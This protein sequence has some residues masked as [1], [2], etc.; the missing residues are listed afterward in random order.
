MVSYFS[1]VATIILTAHFDP[2]IL[3]LTFM[4]TW[5]NNATAPHT[6]LFSF[7]LLFYCYFLL[8]I[9]FYINEI[10]SSFFYVFCTHS[11]MVW[12]LFLGVVL[13]HFSSSAGLFFH[14]TLHCSS[15]YNLCFLYEI[16]GWPVGDIRVVQEKMN[17]KECRSSKA[18]PK[19][20]IK[21]R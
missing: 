13:Y 16:G 5:I 19:T 6:L 7:F 21:T 2:Y 8:S 18:K 17:K 20:K 15:V 11:I 1:G 3:H 12:F 14:F 10:W 4:T 9:V